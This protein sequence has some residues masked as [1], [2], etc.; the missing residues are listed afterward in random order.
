MIMNEEQKRFL[1]AWYNTYTQ[2]EWAYKS[3]YELTKCDIDSPMCNAIYNTF[4]RYTRAV[5][6]LVGDEKGLLGWFI[7]DNKCGERGYEVNVTDKH[8]VTHD[9]A[10]CTLNDLIRALEVQGK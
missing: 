5:E 7:Y 4:D 3:L 2:I 10:V 6:K 9:I 1:A 8:G